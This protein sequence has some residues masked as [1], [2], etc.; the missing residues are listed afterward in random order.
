MMKDD[1]IVSGK[2]IGKGAGRYIWSKCPSCEKRRWLKLGRR[3]GLCGSCSA[4]KN[5][6]TS[7]PWRRREKSVW[8]KGG[9]FYTDGYIFV[10]LAEDDFFYPMTRKRTHYVQEHRLVMAKHLNRCLLPW[11]VVHH[12]NGIRDDNRLENLLLLPD[13]KYHVVD[14]TLKSRIKTLEGENGKLRAQLQSLGKY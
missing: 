8:W 9:R 14:R 7:A 1:E 3:G 2:I 4:K 12:K 13:D 10:N 6:F 11:E 5:H